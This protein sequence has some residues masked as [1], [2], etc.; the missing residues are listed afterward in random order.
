[1]AVTQT[2]SNLMNMKRLLISVIT[3][4]I[5]LFFVASCYY[6]NE[7][8][9]YPELNNACDTTNVTFSASIAPILNSYCTTCHSGSPPSGGITLTSYSS[10][11]AQASSGML[12]NALNGKG[13]SIMPP[14]GSLPACKT[15]QFQIWIRNGMP[16]N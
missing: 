12:M 16:N 5:F 13:V 15:A 14:S 9:L 2:I 11:L 6:D 3:I 7:E 10:V 4:I 1:M 8:A